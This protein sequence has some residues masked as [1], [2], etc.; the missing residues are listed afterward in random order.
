MQAGTLTGSCRILVVDDDAPTRR[1]LSAALQGEEPCEIVT[2]EDAGKALAIFQADPHFHLIVCD[3][4]MPG[5]SGLELIQRVRALNQHT[6]ILVLSS[7]Q[8]ASSVAQA[9]EG[10]ADDYLQKPVDLH[11]LRRAVAALLA[12]AAEA[13]PA[14]TVSA[15]TGVRTEPDGMFVELTAPTSRQQAD[16]FQRFTDRLLNAALNERERHELHL[17]LEEILSN[18]IE[19]G[20][21]ND[22]LKQLHLSYCLLPDRI[23][24]RIEDEGPGF[25]PNSL[26]DPSL[27]PQA[28]IQ[29]RRAS[30]KRMGG[31]GIFLTRKIMDQVTFSPKGNVVFLTKFLRHNGVAKNGHSSGHSV[32]SAG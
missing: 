8:T 4:L 24:F 13:P 5:L 23:T 22:P 31:W 19:W 18:A 10:G 21:R 29:E 11:V 30:G 28:H 27:D 1:L 3:W 2:V 17:S 32:G 6:P 15:R 7:T 25:N 26:K 16:R 9:L 20:N 14:E 12:Q